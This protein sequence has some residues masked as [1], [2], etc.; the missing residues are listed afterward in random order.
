MSA[1]TRKRLQQNPVNEV[2]AFHNSTMAKPVT[3]IQLGHTSK[4]KSKSNF[5]SKGVTFNF[6]S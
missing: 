6:F 3:D 4:K 5:A 1:K 2:D